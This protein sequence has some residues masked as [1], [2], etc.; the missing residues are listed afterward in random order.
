MNRWI[1]LSLCA[2]GVGCKAPPEAP[3]ELSDLSKYLVREWP[4]ED[5]EFLTVGLD[6]LHAALAGVDLTGD[7]DARSWIASPLEPVDLTELTWPTERDP[8]NAPGVAVARESIYGSLDH[9]RLQMESDQ[10]PTE[11]TAVEYVRTFPGTDDP[12]CFPNRE[13]DPIYSLSDVRRQNFLMAVSFELHKSFRW[14]EWGDGQQAIVARSW[15]EQ[16]WF[17]DDGSTKLWQSY[18]VD[19]WLE[20]DADTV[21]RYQVNWS[22]SEVG[23]T[24]DDLVQTTVKNS[25]NTIFEKNDE[26]IGAL[27]YGEG[28]AD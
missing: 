12:A 20:I 21:W 24:S 13:C 11:P 7:V 19:V 2:L 10:L 18:S 14:A 28:E 9:A 25:I 16:S 4:Q 15:F 23:P 22:E 5:S 1:L 8:A 27:Y 6:N 17:G 3:T 26:V